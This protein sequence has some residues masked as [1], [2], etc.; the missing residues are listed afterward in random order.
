MYGLIN[1]A[2]KDLVLASQGESL[3]EKICR[4]VGI[5]PA[6]FEMLSPYP[7]R[8]TSAIVTTSATY[9]HLPTDT[10]L[11]KLGH[12]WIRFTAERGYGE[13]LDL[14]GRDLS[15]CLRNLNQMHAHLGAMMTE[16]KPPSFFVT[17]LSEKRLTIRYHSH[18]E[19][20]AP[21]VLGLLEGLAERLQQRI[22]VEHHPKGARSDHEEFDVT[23][24]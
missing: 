4:D 20:L 22:E 15:T 8:L 23:I 1:Q 19:G 9:L 12:H 3:W 7:D 13:M 21:M 14:L 6:D 18:R 11:R 10:F 17:P 2:V 24:L 16:L 5:D